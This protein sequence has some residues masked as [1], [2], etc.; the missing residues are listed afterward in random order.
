[1]TTYQSEPNRYKGLSLLAFVI[2]L[3]IFLSLMTSC[4]QGTYWR[5]S[6]NR[7][8]EKYQY[9]KRVWPSD[10]SCAAYDNGQP[11]KSS[12]MRRQQYHR[13]HRGH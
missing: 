2:L 10:A 5:T 11:V 8:I 6:H 9:N 13:Y 12:T 4:H 1:M 3:V 7:G